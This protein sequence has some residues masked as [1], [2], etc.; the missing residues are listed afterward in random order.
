M[1]FT[2]LK[3]RDLMLCDVIYQRASKISNWSDYITVLYRDMTTMKKEKM[4]IKDPTIELYT[5]KPEYRTFK[6]PRQFIE[7]DRTTSKTVKYRDVYFEIAKEAGPDYVEFCKTHSKQEQKK[8]LKYPYCLGGDV[9]IETYYRSLW[10]REVGKPKN[11]SISKIY[12]DIEVDQ[13]DHTGGIARHG[14]V[15]VN[16]VTVVDDVTNISYTFLLNTNNSG[17]HPNPQITDFIN[18]QEE[19]QKMCHENFDERYGVMDYKIY[20][21]DNELEM[22][23]QLFLLINSLCRDFCLIWN[24]SFDIPYLLDRVEV[25]GGNV[26]E[27]VCSKDFPTKSYYYYE[28]RRSFEFANKRDYFSCAANTHYSDQLINYAGLRKSQGAVKKVSLD[29][30]G[31]KEIKSTKLDYHEEA[32]IKTLPYVNYILFVLY[33]INDVLLQKGIENKV[34]DVDNIYNISNINDVGFTDTLKQTV[35]F[36]GFMYTYLLT[37]GFIMGHN[38]NFDNQNQGHLQFDED[39]EPIYRDEDDEN[40]G[41]STFEGALNGDPLLNLANGL[42]MYGLPSKFLYGLTIDQDFSSM[43]P[44]RNYWAA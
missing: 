31:E 1:P 14:E 22:L 12:L 37:H 5:V 25:L 7:L 20:M 32:T 24:M 11:K 16:A 4:V 8:M 43:Y 17:D 29:A 40:D 42:E 34:K 39:G 10:N 19:F 3:G 9:P 13:I 27:I 28:D 15:P 41:E 26:E 23:T 30:I 44:N 21:F 35:V 6:K 18:N 36:R 2:K 33:N 38:T